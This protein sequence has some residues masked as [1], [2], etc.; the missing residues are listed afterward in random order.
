[1]NKTLLLIIC[2]FLLLNLLALTRWEKAEPTRPQRSPVPRVSAAAAATQDQDLVETMRL[3]LEDERTTRSQIAQ[4]LASTET[5]LANREQNL[6]TLAEEKTRLA[7]T[8]TT[9]QQQA[10]DL[11][12]RLAGATQDAA[13]SKERLAELQKE[14]EARQAEA[15]RQKE[16]LAALEKTQGEAREKIEGLTVAVKVAEQEKQLLRS[17]ADTLKQ[18]VEAERQ[19]RV[20]VQATTVQLAQGVGQLAEKSGELSKEIRDNRPINAN[21]LYSDYLANRVLTKFT[22]TRDGLLGEYSRTRETQTVLVTDGQQVYALL[23]LDDTPFVYQDQPTADWKKIAVEFSRPATHSAAAM[24]NF[25]ALD[26]RILVLPVDAAQVAALGVKVYP[27]APDPFKFPEAM[28]VSHGGGGYGELPFRLDSQQPG[29]VRMDSNL[30]KRLAGNFSPS[31]GDLV[32]SRSGELLGIMVSANYCAIVNNFLPARS[33]TLGD[34][35]AQGTGKLI[36]DLA[37]RYR[38]LPFRLQ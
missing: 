27:T 22:A 6:T 26:P 33:L 10:A 12:R 16:Q 34:T 29:F 37:A 9:T 7:S 25:L 11:G 28:L 38:S 36:D 21:V 19:E 31:R 35:A 32:F 1:M 4:Q 17:T 20:K 23:H 15:A 18:Q 13:I 30:F 5:T 24:L 14:L 8:L 2:D 3:S